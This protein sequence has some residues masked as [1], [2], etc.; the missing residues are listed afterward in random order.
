MAYRL[1]KLNSRVFSTADIIMDSDVKGK[2]FE[3]NSQK[4]SFKS[5][6]YRDQFEFPREKLLVSDM[7]LGR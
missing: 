5:L 2:S 6:H 3:S 1:S 4:R 7:L